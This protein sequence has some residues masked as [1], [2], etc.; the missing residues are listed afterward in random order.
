MYVSDWRISKSSGAR[1]G[2]IEEGGGVL[3]RGGIVGS[4]NSALQWSEGNA[5]RNEFRHRYS[6]SIARR[7]RRRLW[8]SSA[9]SET[10]EEEED[11]SASFRVRCG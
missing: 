7:R 11:F 8:Q 3:V 6:G 2:I 5:R 4:G 1:V 9:D 10:E